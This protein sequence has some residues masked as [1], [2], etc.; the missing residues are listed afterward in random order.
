MLPEISLDTNSFEEIVKKARSQ[1]SEICPQWTDYNYHDPGITILEMFAF[2]KEAQQFYIDQISDEVRKKLLQLMGI[3]LIKRHSSTTNVRIFTRSPLT[4]PAGAKFYINGLCFETTRIEN[5]PGD[6]IKAVI[7]K[8][9]YGSV[10]KTELNRS[11]GRGSVVIYPFGKKTGVGSEFLIC[12]DKR[13]EKEKLYRLSISIDEHY[14]VKRNQIEDISSFVA[15]SKMRVTY[16]DGIN[17]NDI[18]FDDSTVGMIRNGDIVFSISNDMALSVEEGIEGYFIKFCLIEDNLDVAPA[19]KE[20]G[21]T[22]VTLIQKDTKAVF[23]SKEQK[24]LWKK[25]SIKIDYYAWNEINGCYIDTTEDKADKIAVYEEDFYKNKVLAVGNGLPNQCYDVGNS[26]LMADLLEILVSS[27]K[28]K[29]F[30]RQWVKVKDFDSSGPDDCHYVV[31]EEKGQVY[32][33]NGI[34]GRM[35]EAEIRIVS[36][37]FCS[38]SRGNIKAGQ[39]AESVSLLNDGYG[40]SVCDAFGGCEPESIENGFF[41]A[42]KAF[43]EKER[44]VTGNDY[45]KLIMSTP[46]LRIQDCKT[47]E[48]SE[49]SGEHYENEV[50]IVVRP[51]SENGYAVLSDAYKRNILNQIMGKRIIGTSVRLYSPIYIDVNVYME[52]RVKPQYL[53]SENRIKDSVKEFFSS[54]D[55]FGA[56]INYSSLFACVNGLEEV[57]EVYMLYIDAE[58]GRVSRNR[59]G[60]IILPSLGVLLLRNIDCVVIN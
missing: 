45:E 59:N 18:K 12:L 39:T 47:L 43:E 34:R 40:Y 44:A 30:F 21:F 36:C 32:F 26:G 57:M 11:K 42:R 19:I 16:F 56:V 10:F 58:G 22:D 17:E 46:G 25:D 27:V 28:D 3:S 23:L 38:G 15:L 4:F 52:L 37:G 35:P 14:S 55:G 2:L 13:L 5:I 29:G 54:I 53:N 50:R 49:F 9:K 8:P 24:E 51:Y 41:R 1:I 31:D 7:V 48:S 33:G 6:I 20:I 60:D